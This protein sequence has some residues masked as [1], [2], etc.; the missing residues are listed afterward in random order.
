METNHPDTRSATAR[1]LENP[2]LLA[3]KDTGTPNPQPIPTAADYEAVAAEY[4]AEGKVELAARALAEADAT[5]KNEARR[6]VVEID[7]EMADFVRNFAEWMRWTPQDVVI[8]L[9]ASMLECWDGDEHETVQ[10][11]FN[12]C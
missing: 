12:S 1:L 2:G 8:G 3:A 4:R 5:R 9:T 10:A 6:F 7:G 11:L